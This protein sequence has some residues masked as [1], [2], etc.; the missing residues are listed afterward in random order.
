MLT[1]VVER[2]TCRP[3]WA[4]FR[5]AVCQL[6][7]VS[8]VEPSRAPDWLARLGEALDAA[9]VSL[10]EID[11][12]A[13][14]IGPGSFSGTRA[15]VAA[16]QGMALPGGKPLV[17]VSSAAALAFSVL[18]QRKKCGLHTPVS[19][20]GDARRERLWCAVYALEG[21]RLMVRTAT[22]ARPPTHAAAD[23][24]LTTGADLPGRLPP[25]TAVVSPDWER[26]GARLLSL[27]PASDLV[28]TLLTPTA[29]DVGRLLLS[30]PA[31]AHA[32]PMP[33]YLHPAVAEART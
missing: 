32:E 27:L 33:I 9:G 23:F 29:A 30:D 31:A 18:S 5:D 2:S 11:R 6:E 16:L 20:V 8:D 12:F 4:L 25:D 1:L 19:V 22:G 28:S 21:T 10:A 3:G 14:G 26:I 13:A 7:T 15:A 24:T 17:G